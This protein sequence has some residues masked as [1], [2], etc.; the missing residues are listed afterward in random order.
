[1]APELLGGRYELRGILGRG[2]MAEVRDG[3]DTRLDRA[4]AIKLLHPFLSTQT[5]SRRRFEAEARSAAGLNHPNI[6]AV[7]DS[8][9]HGN[10]PYIVMER[11]PG[12]SLADLIAYGPVPQ[13][14]VRAVLDQVLA[15]LSFAHDA[16]IVHRDIKPGNIL[17]TPAGDAKVADFGIAKSAEIDQ[18]VT[19]QILGT[20]AYLSP[21]RLAGRPACAGDDLY[22]LGVVG[23]EALT[24]RRPFGG[25]NLGALARAIMDERPPPVAALRPDVDPLLADVVERAMAREPVWRFA[26]AWDMR[27]ALVGNFASGH[28]ATGTGGAALARGMRPPTMLLTHPPIP[29]YA[30]PRRGPMRTSRKLLLAAAALIAIAVAAVAFVMESASSGNMPGSPAV[31]SSTMVPLSSFSPSPPSPPPT[32][33]PADEPGPRHGRGHGHKDG[34]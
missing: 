28:I 30:V 14:V 6:V 12:R 20:L 17:F 7:H 18:T 11:L 10:T 24:G 2:G 21:E 3:W 31:P 13:P 23:Y 29:T 34:D 15:A 26:G 5:E 22:A 8:G 16:G 27:A 9:E 1:M 25:D 32:P 4:V 19:G 33:S